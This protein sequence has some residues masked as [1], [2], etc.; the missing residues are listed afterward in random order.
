MPKGKPL[1]LSP[2]EMELLIS[3]ANGRRTYADVATQLSLPVSTV[4][5]IARRYGLSYQR[6]GESHHSS[7]YPAATVAEARRRHEAGEAVDDIAA[8]LGIPH[9]TVYSWV[10]MYTRWKEAMTE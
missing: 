2:N 9:P 8:S 1:K 7:R 3:S 6:H 10:A 4:A 5:T